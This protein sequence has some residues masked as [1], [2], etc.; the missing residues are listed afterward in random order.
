[1]I[2]WFSCFM[3]I[4]LFY[5]LLEGFRTSFQIYHKTSYVFFI[6]VEFF[7]HVI[8]SNPIFENPYPSMGGWLDD[9]TLYALNWKSILT[10]AWKGGSMSYTLDPHHFFNWYPN[11]YF[12]ACILIFDFLYMYASKLQNVSISIG[13]YCFIHIYMIWLCLLYLYI[14]KHKLCLC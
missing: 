10:C 8:S 7:K 14:L 4:L 2:M 13:I 3:D 11:W 6:L 1:M 9:H 12:H 5:S